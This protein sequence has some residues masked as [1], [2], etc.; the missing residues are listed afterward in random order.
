MENTSI[1]AQNDLQ[2]IRIRLKQMEDAHS[3]ERETRE[4]YEN[5]LRKLVEAQIEIDLETKKP[6]HQRSKDPIAKKQEAIKEARRVLGG[7][8]NAKNNDVL[9]E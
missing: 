1:T 6:L 7:E 4:K 9:G 3:R 8:K 5:I 2:N